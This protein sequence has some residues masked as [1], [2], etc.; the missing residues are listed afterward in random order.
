VQTNDLLAYA[1][2]G[3]HRGLGDAA[4]CVELCNASCMLSARWAQDLESSEGS[5]ASDNT[6][7]DDAF[8]GDFSRGRRLRELHKIIG[9]K[10][11]GVAS[12]VGVFDSNMHACSNTN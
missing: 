6:H 2:L 4:F 7:S 9:N 10:A 11:V 12:A 1:D 5:P 3:W 8:E